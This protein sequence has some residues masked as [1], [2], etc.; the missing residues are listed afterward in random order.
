M[1]ADKARALSADERPRQAGGA[2]RWKIPA[3]GHPDLQLHQFRLASHLYFDAIQFRVAAR[4]YFAHLQ[5]R[6]VHERLRGDS[7]AQQTP[8][9]RRGMKARR[10]R[11]EKIS[12]IF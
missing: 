4:A 11:C 3:R 9:T 2:A 5:I 1:A 8:T 7:R 6:P 10:M 12:R